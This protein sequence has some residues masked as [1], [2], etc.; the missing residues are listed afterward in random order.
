[1]DCNKEFIVKKLITIWFILLGFVVA[2][3]E[4]LYAPAPPA[5]AAFVRIIHASPD[6]AAVSATLGDTAYDEVAFAEV[7]PYRVVLQGARTL[8]A[9]DVT[10]DLEVQAGKFYSLA[11]TPDG[12]V[13]LEDASSSNRAKALLLLYNLSDIPA[14]DLKT[15]DGKTEVFSGVA[16]GTQTSVEVNGITVDLAVLGEGA[17]LQEFPGVQLERG[18]AYSALVLGTASAPTVI[19]VQSET[20][21]E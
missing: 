10:Q 16:P 13:V 2:Q 3:E 8:T 19:W 1:L 6:A 18:A 14:V 9:G 20:T 12:V 7:S 15:A 5:D 11:I 17:V 21:T 4:G